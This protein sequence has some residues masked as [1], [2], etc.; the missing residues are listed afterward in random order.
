MRL[1]MARQRLRSALT[2]ISG[3]GARDTPASRRIAGCAV[4][5]SLGLYCLTNLLLLLNTQAVQLFLMNEITWAEAYVLY[6]VAHFQHTGAIYRDLSQAPY[7]PTVY[8]PLVYILY[9]LPGRLV[10]FENPYLGLRLVSVVMFLAAIGVTVSIAR[11]LVPARRAW[12]WGLLL[13]TSILPFKDWVLSFHGDFPGAAFSLLAVRLLL[14]RSPG[15]ALP[16]GLCAGLATQFKIT[17][18]AALA[19]GSVWLLLRR[20]WGQSATF[21]AA[22]VLTSVG[23]YFLVWLREPGMLPQIL[24]LSPAVKDPGG[25]VMLAYHAVSEPV[26]LLALPALVPFPGRG[27]PRWALLFL[28]VLVSFVTAALA[29]IQAGGNINYFFAAFLGVVPASVLGVYR[30]TRWARRRIGIAAFMAAIFI[31]LW[32]PPPALEL[33]RALRGESAGNIVAVSNDR[34]RKW[35]DLLHGRH[36]FSTIPGLA[37][38]DPVPTLTEPYLLSYLQRLG[39]FDPQPI[40]GRIRNGEFDIVLTAANSM[41]WRGVAAIDPDLREAIGSAYRPL[42]TIKGFGYGGNALVQTP[43]NGE[44]DRGLVAALEENG[45]AP[46]TADQISHPSW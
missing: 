30:L 34:F 18:V 3:I 25:A 37:L 15:A 11:T 38:L 5:G 36:I 13:S 33:F 9:S 26:V 16:A 41:S 40:L 32:W 27:S 14:S 17:F 23:L 44:K 43:R 19:A 45:C 22:G 10:T 21:A 2:S 12:C 39:K 46:L 35:R 29:D 31:L 28:F 20:R 4:A 1:M 6:D 24:A 42:C 7:L 8:G